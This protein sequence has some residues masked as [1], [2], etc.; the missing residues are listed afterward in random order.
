MQI[1]RT[2]S[3]ALT[4]NTLPDGS[5]VIVDSANQTVLAL[6]ATAGAAWDACSTPTSLAGVAKTMRHSF[7]QQTTEA[8]AK[9]AIL[10]LEEHNLV[11]TSEMSESGGFPQQPGRRQFIATLSAAALPLVVSLT[12]ADQQAY[13]KSARSIVTQPHP[14]H[15]HRHGRDND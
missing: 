14:N 9:E 15:G 7:D 2:H 11:R 1:E 6:N 10:Q 3:D 12:L 5:R 8:G 4:I 13:A